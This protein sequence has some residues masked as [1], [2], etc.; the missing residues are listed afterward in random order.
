MENRNN[1]R[2][3]EEELNE[4][5]EKQVE[6]FQIALTKRIPYIIVLLDIFAVAGIGIGMMKFQEPE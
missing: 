5:E 2:R 3:E 4:E 6:E 1:E